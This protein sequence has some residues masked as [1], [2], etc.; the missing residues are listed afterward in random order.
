[1]TYKMSDE[2]LNEVRKLCSDK[3]FDEAETATIIEIVKKVSA[4]IME[5][6]EYELGKA[7]EMLKCGD[8]NA[9][10]MI[11]LAN[12]N[13]MLGKVNVHRASLFANMDIPPPMEKYFDPA[14]H[15]PGFVH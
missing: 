6:Y 2:S 10:A 4:P 15:I 7:I 14:E 13:H 9:R 3:G 1:M 5:R 11:F 12:T 8:P